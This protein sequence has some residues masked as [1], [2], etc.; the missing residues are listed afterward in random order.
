MS[1][2]RKSDGSPEGPTDLPDAVHRL[3]ITVTDV[4]EPPDAP[5]TGV[6]VTGASSTSLTVS[7]TAPDGTG[8]P[9][10]TGYDIRWFE[11]SADPDREA[12]WTERAF[13]GTATSRIIT[14]L[15]L[16]STYRVQ[17]R[18]K[19]HEGRAPWSDSGSG[20]TSTGVP[21]RCDDPF[22]NDR[23]E[24]WIASVTSTRTSITVTLNDPP[25]AGSVVL[26]IC[27]TRSSDAPFRIETPAVG[28][29]TIT[30]RQPDTDYWVRVASTNSCRRCAS[31]WHHV[32]TKPN[33]AAPG[34]LDDAPTEL[35][36]PESAASGA[37][38]GTVA[39]T[40]PDGD[41]LTYLLDTES[42]A[43]FDID[44]D[45]AITVTAAGVL[46]HE[47][48]P[49]WPVTVSVSDGKAPDFSDDTDV[50]ATHSLTVTV[51][52]VPE[53]P[54]APTGVTVTGA[55]LRSMAV[56]WTAPDVTGKPAL[57][58]YDVRWF[59]GASDPADD[60]DWVEPGEAGGHDHVGTD[61]TAEIGGLDA[62][63]A[64]RVQ[65][66]AANEEGKSGW[67]ASGGGSTATAPTV[68]GVALVSTPTA[69]V[70]GN[71][72]NETYKSGDT[73]RARVTFSA[74]VDVTGGPVLKLQLAENSGESP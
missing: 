65:V 38:V 10:I 22:P 33:N 71:D 44:G 29:Y 14:G 55:S 50:D 18:A 73:V 59:K 2:G 20:S 30:G 1:D 9:V 19:N 7:W 49:Y 66:R 26:F 31:V 16:G 46:D 4:D 8:K 5:P 25:R 69:D 24:N 13:S 40:D 48:T 54:D 39:A 60:A 57:T 23:V 61:T 64:Y 28:D 43:V 32:R 17:V 74:P 34:F 56:S 58:D 72:T 21:D 51:T 52:D 35:S 45:G 41:T 42:D 15:K 63:S 6:T 27:K 37:V 53:S 12:L 36:V 11:G 70:D 67:S 47:D 68:S 62:E 3:T